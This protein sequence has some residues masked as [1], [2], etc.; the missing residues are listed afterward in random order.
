V[1]LTSLLLVVTA[2]LLWGRLAPLRERRR[3]G[4]TR[5]TVAAPRGDLL[6]ALRPKPQSM[7]V[8][9]ERAHSVANLRRLRRKRSSRREAK[10]VAVRERPQ[11]AHVDAAVDRSEIKL[12]RGFLKCHLYAVQEGSEEEPIAF[13]PYFRLLE[14]DKSSSEG[15]QA[16]AALVDELKGDGWAVVNDGPAWYEHRLERRA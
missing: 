9:A 2:I 14:D 12:W 16:L 5:A 15:L 11:P 13:S 3:W 4:L 1:F 7:R 8:V 10:S 6:E